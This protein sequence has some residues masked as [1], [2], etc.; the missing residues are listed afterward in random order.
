MARGCA[1]STRTG[2]K[3]TITECARQDTIPRSIN[4]RISGD[5]AV[6]VRVWRTRRIGV[7]RNHFSE[8]GTDVMVRTTLLALLPRTP[9]ILPSIDIVTVIQSPCLYYLLVL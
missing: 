9:F 1:V 3:C 6:V 5:C 2:S 8:R 7:Q 4:K